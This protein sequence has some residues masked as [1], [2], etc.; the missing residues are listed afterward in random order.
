MCPEP[1]LLS[2]Y[3]D[4]ELPSPWKEKME[5]HLAECSACADRY[6]NF[7]HLQEMFKKST[8][9]RRTYVE[10]DGTS[11]SSGTTE[12]ALPEQEFIEE[13]KE[14]VWRKMESSRR[15]RHLSVW[16]HRLSIPLPAVAAAA[17]IVLTILTVLFVRSTGLQ[18]AD[19]AARSNFILAYEEEEI[20]SII[21][22]ADMSGLLQLLDTDG[23]EVIILRLPETRNFARSGEPAII[24]AADYSRR[25]P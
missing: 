15:Y 2:I 9:Q 25:Y 23:T 21:P 24:R 1:Q 16:R 20:P 17:A 22:T 13:A 19:P 4:G 10:S 12:Q 11:L 7:R 8:R 14:K 3:M 18:S 6:K 5:A